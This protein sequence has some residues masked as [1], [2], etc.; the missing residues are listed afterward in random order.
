MDELTDGAEVLAEDERP[1]IEINEG[2]EA[3]FDEVAADGSPLTHPQDVLIALEPT[4]VEALERG[5]AGGAL[6]TLFDLAEVCHPD[7]LDNY[8]SDEGDLLH[9]VDV[10]VGEPVHAALPGEVWMLSDRHV[11]VVV[12]LVTDWP[13]WITYLDDHAK[14]FVPYPEP[15]VTLTDI[16]RSKLLVMVQPDPY[17]AGHVLDKHAAF[18]G[19]ETIR[20]VLSHVW[21]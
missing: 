5:G 3:M 17:L 12:D 20:K 11:L 15:Y 21:R 1:P 4:P 7:Q 9:L 14:L 8:L 16:A 10:A 18:F 13:R 19:E 2:Q 6:E